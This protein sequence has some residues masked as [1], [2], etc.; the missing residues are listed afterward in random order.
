MKSYWISL[1][2][3]KQ[4]LPISGFFVYSNWIGIS[5]NS[6]KI[7]EFDYALKRENVNTAE[8]IF[9]LIISSW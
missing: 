4:K 8:I 7:I 6:A 1:F 5:Q 9:G 3:K 2:K